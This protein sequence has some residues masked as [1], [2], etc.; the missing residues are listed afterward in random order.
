MWAMHSFVAVRVVS[1][2]KKPIMH[3]DGTEEHIT[4]VSPKGTALQIPRLKSYSEV[5]N[6]LLKGYKNDE[7]T[8]KTDLAILRFKKLRSMKL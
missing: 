8:A 1:L 2:L 5:V 3:S 6:Y 7:A 4:T